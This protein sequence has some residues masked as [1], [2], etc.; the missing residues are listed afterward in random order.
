MTG[1]RADRTFVLAVDCL[2]GHS[3]ITD[4]APFV[5]GGYAIAPTTNPFSGSLIAP[6]EFTGQ[7]WAIAPDGGVQLVLAPELPTGGDIGVE[8][9]G[10]V[11]PGFISGGGA[12]YLADR[13]TP[14]N[15][16]P[17]TDTILRLT[18][19]SLASAGVLD[20]D[21]LVSTEGGGLTIAVR[22]DAASCT[23]FPVAHGPA[24]STVGHIEGRITVTP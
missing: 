8:S 17:G 22:C 10:F 9:L 24:A 2:G 14:G 16:F 12:A 6:D 4:T 5:E 23:S 18:A 20:G 11:P 3:V 15:P 13:G 7:I 21:L 19:A 1:T